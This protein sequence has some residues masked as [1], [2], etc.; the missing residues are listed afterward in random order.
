MDYL[1]QL[2]FLKLIEEVKICG[3]SS[4]AIALIS[5][6]NFKNQKPQPKNP[7]ILLLISRIFIALLKHLFFLV[8]CGIHFGFIECWTPFF[9]LASTKKYDNYQQ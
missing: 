3:L 5:Q 7:P 1:I 8:R 2:D 6:K 9:G 4:I